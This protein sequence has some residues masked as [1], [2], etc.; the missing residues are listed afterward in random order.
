MKSKDA[1]ISS[2]VRAIFL[3]KISFSISRNLERFVVFT[4]VM[5]LIRLDAAANV[6]V[7]V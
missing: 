7:E 1:S 6:N 2:N 5:K 4:I 3:F